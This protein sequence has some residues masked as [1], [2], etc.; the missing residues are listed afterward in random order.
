MRTVRTSVVLA[1]ALSLVAAC[2]VV[3]SPPASAAAGDE[4][5]YTWVDPADRYSQT[6]LRVRDA[7]AGTDVLLPGSALSYPIEDVRLLVSR[8]GRRIARIVYDETDFGARLDVYDRDTGAATFVDHV[9]PDTAFTT[10][11]WMPDG[12]HLLVGATLPEGR[13]TNLRVV[14][15]DGSSRTIAGTAAVS[16]ADVSPSGDVVAYSAPVSG[17]PHLWLMNLDGTSQRD[18]GVVGTAPSWTH[19]GQH[20]LATLW[21]TGPGGE[22]AG[23]VLESVTPLGLRRTVLD[24]T[25]VSGGA[26]YD[27]SPDGSTILASDGTSARATPLTGSG[28]WTDVV[29]ATGSAAYAGPWTPTDVTAPTLNYPPYV[30]LGATS[31]QVVWSPSFITGYDAVGVRIAVAPGLVPPA[32]YSAGARRATV[33]G[34]ASSTVITGLT[35]GATYS[36]SMWAI[37]GS[38]NASE[39]RTGHFRLIPALSTVT[40]PAIASTTSTGWLRLVYATTATGAAGTNLRATVRSLSGSLTQPGM[41]NPGLALPMSG[42]Y[43]Y[44]RGGY[45]ETLVPGSNYTVTAGARDAWG[46]VRWSTSTVTVQ[47]PVDDRGLAYSGTWGRVASSTAWQGTTSVTT[48]G[49]RAALTVRNRGNGVRHFAVVVTKAPGGGRFQVYVDGRYVTTV[50]TASTST[51]VRQVAW[52]SVTLTRATHSLLLVHVKGSGAV[53]LDAVATALG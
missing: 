46:N 43:S 13:P 51:R 27:L 10:V 49:G 40:G 15:L 39:P 18:L 30:L 2:L 11:A 44:G 5:V 26:W 22:R 9:G 25:F 3:L 12:T 8:D 6:F 14:G 23:S 50:S 53:R 28:G 48:A 34:R 41:V 31:V 42:V 35:A 32:T 4:V 1:A 36:Y 24:Q 37:D 38:G 52:T 16:A 17:V 45:P 19:D 33:L 21:L 7:V 47:Y 29:G 20:L